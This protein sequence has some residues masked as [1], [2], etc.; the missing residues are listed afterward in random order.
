MSGALPAPVGDAQGLLAD[1]FKDQIVVV[2]GGFGGI[3]AEVARQAEALGAR[4][5]AASR[6]VAANTAD[7]PR[8]EARLDHTDAASRAEFVAWLTATV[9]RVDILVNTAGMTRSVPLKAIERLDDGLIDAVMASNATGVLKLI[10]DLVPLLRAGHA[11]CIVNVSSVAARTGVGS[12][13]AYVGAKAAMDA[14]SVSLAKALAPEIRIVNVA[15]SALDTDFAQG[16]P[17]DFID[18]TIAATPLGRLATTT[19]VANAVLAA[20]RLLTMTTGETIV[21][22]GGRRL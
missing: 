15:P 8:L 11:P 3:G 14:M 7:G 18:R 16:R 1:G 9:G 10:R 4:V 21:V 19:E 22:D 12:N 5:V 13:I 6:R 20:A 17:Q 2:V